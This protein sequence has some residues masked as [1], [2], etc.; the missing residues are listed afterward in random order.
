MIFTFLYYQT[1][2]LSQTSFLYFQLSALGLDLVIMVHTSFQNLIESTKLSNRQPDIHT[3]TEGSQNWSSYMAKNPWSIILR[4]Y[5]CENL[6]FPI[7]KWHQL[8]KL[9]NRA[10]CAKHYSKYYVCINSVTRQSTLVGPIHV[11]PGSPWS[12][13]VVGEIYIPMHTLALLHFARFFMNKVCGNPTFSKS[14]DTTFFPNTICLLL[15]F[16]AH[17]GNSYNISNFS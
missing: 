9:T 4:K 5:L 2:L 13:R 3:I 6:P 11:R 10:Q 15:V 12:S 7:A 17:F 1:L 16:V 14:I 8:A